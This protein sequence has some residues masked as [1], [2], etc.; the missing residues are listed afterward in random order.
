MT[1]KPFSLDSELV[2]PHWKWNICIFINSISSIFNY[3]D[4]SLCAVAQYCIAKILPVIDGGGSSINR[5]F[6]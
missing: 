5:L 1:D 2:L 6:V 3:L 4:L